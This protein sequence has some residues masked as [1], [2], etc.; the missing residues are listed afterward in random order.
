MK[1][2]ALVL[3][4]VASPAFCGEYKFIPGTQVTATV[5]LQADVNGELTIVVAGQTITIGVVTTVP[6]DPTNPTDPPGPPDPLA[7]K[8]TALVAS[9]P[10]AMNERKT[11]SELFLKI[12]VFPTDDPDQ[13]RRGVTFLFELL[14]L[15]EWKTWKAEVDSF[16][17]SLAVDD[18]RRAWK[19][20]GE[21]LVDFNAIE[22]VAAE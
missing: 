17:E 18:V 11:V 9:A 3:M 22:A 14:P 7:V 1:R 13:L 21:G 19:L 12:A 15:K 16:A 5:V 4:L 2:L 8:V 10:M 6:K 20:I